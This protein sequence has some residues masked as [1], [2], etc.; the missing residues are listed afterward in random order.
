ME[1]IVFD[2]QMNQ[3]TLIPFTDL[4]FKRHIFDPREFNLKSKFKLEPG[5]YVTLIENRT[6]KFSGY[7]T[8][9]DE[10]SQTISASG[11]DLRFLLCGVQYAHLYGTKFVDTVNLTISNTDLIRNLIIKAFAGYSIT[12]INNASA[13]S[14]KAEIRIKSVYE[15]L[16]ACCLA[17]DIYYE[18]YLTG[19]KQLILKIEPIRDL[20][21]NTPLITNITHA[22]T[23][24]IIS[25]K[26]KYN[27]ILGLGAGEAG[28]RD[29][30][31]INQ[32]KSGEFP[33]CYVYDLREDITHDEL[34]QRT[35]VK[36]KELRSEYSVKFQILENKVLAF[37][38]DYG[39]GDYVSFKSADGRVFDDLITEYQTQIQNG[40][41]IKGY[42]VS[43]GLTKGNISDKLKELKE[44]GFK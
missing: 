21:S 13:I 8:D 28:D 31:F 22:E 39:L 29:F 20:R 6:P 14:Y 41:L 18:L 24:K 1:C 32:C 43:I 25:V 38:I 17:T 23:E 19:S 11:Y 42:E 4:N 3:K 36:F 5:E 35:D 27:Q 10:Q 16:R 7:V 15:I 30:Y 26:E 34:A 33:N 37:G 44:G 2:K 40:R 12:V 9:I